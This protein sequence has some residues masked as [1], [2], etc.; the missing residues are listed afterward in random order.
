[1]TDL[2]DT[3]NEKL[4]CTGIYFEPITDWHIERLS[5]YVRTPVPIDA[6]D[7]I[8]FN[9]ERGPSGALYYNGKLLGI[10]GVVIYWKGVGEVWTIIDD[11]IKQKFKRQ[12]IVGVRTAL[13]I[14]QISLDLHR[15]QVAIESNAEYSQS[16]PLALGFTLEGVMR[17]FGM[18][19]SDYTLYGRIRTCQQ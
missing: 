16:W 14:T 18:D 19:G 6:L 3:V 4:A 7:S 2:I 11:S 1:M 15:V 9:M 17:N 13:D 12:L 8:H 5:Q 10:I